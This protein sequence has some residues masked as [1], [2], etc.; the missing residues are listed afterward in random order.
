MLT[1]SDLIEHLTDYLGGAADNAMQSHI[2]RAAS[3]A[4]KRIAYHPHKWRYYICRSRVNL[5]GI[6][7]TG[8]IAYTASTRTFA[9][10]GGSWPSWAANGE[11]KVDGKLYDCESVSGSSLVVTADNCPVSNISSGT[12]YELHQAS[13][14][15]PVD[16]QDIHFVKNESLWQ[17]RYVSPESWYA[18]NR[19]EGSTGDPECWTVIGDLKK[20]R[21]GRQSLCVYPTPTT[22]AAHEFLMRRKA[23]DMR[24]S[25]YESNPGTIAISGTTVTG[26]STT[27]N[28]KMVGS[29]LRL[30]DSTTTQPTG[31]GGLNP[32]LEEFVITGYTSATSITISGTPIN[33]YSGVK[34][35]VTDPADVADAMQPLLLRGCE[36][37]IAV[38]RNTSDASLGR[39]KALYNE[40][41]IRAMEVDQLTAIA[42]SGITLTSSDA[43][44]YS[45]GNYTAETSNG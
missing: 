36:Y 39:A 40:E 10:S 5:N 21:Y 2:R 6:Y 44:Y 12:S 34:Y 28:S 41:F 23:R 13:Y 16:F 24:L 37:E 14:P 26:T 29:V 19:C 4:Y 11:I 7:S 42:Q 22:D 32:Y 45:L 25:G 35:R 43:D 9:I 17:Q 1:Y 30:T 27:F 20:G 33:T 31:I 3:N 18:L 38:L 8:T 15:L